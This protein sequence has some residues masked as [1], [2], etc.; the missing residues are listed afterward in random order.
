MLIAI[1]LS[2]WQRLGIEWDL[3]VATGR[4]VLQLLVVGYLLAAVFAFREPLPVL[5]LLLGLL[6]VAAIAT[7][8]RISQKVPH[9]LL[10]VAGSV[11]VGTALTLLYT[12]L[13]I[14]R[15]P[16]WYEP[17]VLIPLAAVI[18]G[19]AMN[20]AAIAGDRLVSTLSRSQLEI[21]THLSLGATPQQAVAQYRKDAI[22]TAL[23]P[24]LNT[25]TIVGLVSLPGV[26]TGQLLSGVDPLVATAYQIVIL[27]M[28]AF[29][30]LVTVL[31]V[32][33]GIC[34]QFFNRAAQV[35]LW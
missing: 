21:E 2:A 19:N 31:L 6:A 32:S 22:K 11:L 3:T 23:M 8:N 20:G 10:I 12:M 25:M 16:V 27:F 24:T 5:A 29:A 30:T 7:R 4:T 17:Q 14:I 18:V 35:T 28:L 26:M 15:P 9:L 1:A 34:Q 13:L 33:W